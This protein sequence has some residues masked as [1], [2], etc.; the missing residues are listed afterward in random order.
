MLVAS[1]KSLELLSWCR[2]WIGDGWKMEG[3]NGMGNMGGG[4]CVMAGKGAFSEAAALSITYLPS[5]P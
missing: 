1:G 2:G 5:R 3:K 4:G